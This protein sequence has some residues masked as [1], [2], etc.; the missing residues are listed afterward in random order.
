SGFQIRVLGV[1]ISPPLPYLKPQ[2]K[3]WGFFVFSPKPPTSVGG[4]HSLRL[5]LI[6]KFLTFVSYSPEV[7]QSTSVH[8]FNEL[9]SFV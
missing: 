8:I 7:S 6:P 3:D 1:R 5:C 9:N 2:S 4:Y